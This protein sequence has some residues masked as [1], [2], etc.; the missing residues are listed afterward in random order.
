V[1]ILIPPPN[2]KIL[3]DRLKE[4]QVAGGLNALDGH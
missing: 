3:I 1:L 2:L 4:I